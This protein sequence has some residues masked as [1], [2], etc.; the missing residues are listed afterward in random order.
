[1]ATAQQISANRQNAQKSTGPRTPEGKATVSQNALKHGL[2][3]AAVLLPKEDETDFLEFSQCL[4]SHLAPVGEWEIFLADRIIA[5]AW[6][7]R[8]VTMAETSIFTNKGT[9]SESAAQ[10]CSSD[11]GL[12]FMRAEQETGGLTKL[13]RYEV[14]IERGMYKA[15]H[16]LE[17]RQAARAGQPVPAP[18]AVGVDVAGV[19]NETNGKHTNL[20]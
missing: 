1:M 15:M 19:M 16:D 3:S 5:N 12:S 7:L 6:R 9:L 8:R 2:L 20:H 14:T 10:Y 4:R 11:V 17:L 18:V 13:S